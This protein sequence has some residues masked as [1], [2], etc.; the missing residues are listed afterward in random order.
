MPNQYTPD[1]Q[2]IGNLLSLTNPPIVVPEWQRNFSWTTSEVETF[3]NDLVFFDERY[4]D[5]NMASEE[6][7]LGSIVIVD[8]DVEHIL[9][10]GQQRLA[11]SAILLSVI[12]DFLSRFNIDAATRVSN[13]FLTDYDDALQRTTYKI[14]LNRY[15]RDFF[16]REILES[17]DTS[18][19]EM[20]PQIDS[21]RLIRRSRE[22]FVTK[23][24]NRYEEIGDP[25]AS[26]QWAA[27]SHRSNKSP[28]FSRCSL[29]G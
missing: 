4:P 3:W 16:R 1:K 8:T 10:D 9:L 12:R 23:F 17:R 21:H 11:T 26:H 24:L 27:H 13:R 2:T 19:V 18:Y 25:Q 5:E 20:E 28:I 6:Y 22:F 14:T 29:K 7:F 15:D